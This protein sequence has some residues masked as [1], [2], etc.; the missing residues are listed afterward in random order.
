MP[1][2]PS[3]F[4]LSSRRTWEGG[5]QA[6]SWLRPFLVRVVKAFNTLPAAVLASNPV[7]GDG[8]RVMFVSSDDVD[9]SRRRASRV[10]ATAPSHV[11]QTTRTGVTRS[12]STSISTGRLAAV[13]GQA[14]RQAG[15]P[16]SPP[17]FAATLAE[18]AGKRLKEAR[19]QQFE[20]SGRTGPYTLSLRASIE[21]TRFL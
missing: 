21:G 17:C 1:R 16:S 12:S 20:W 6:K 7:Q 5:Y 2:T 14:T 15:P 18:L 10:R 9:S 3:I 8:W 13:W 4:L 11:M 19:V